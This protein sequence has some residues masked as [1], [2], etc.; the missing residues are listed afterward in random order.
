[1]QDCRENKSNVPKNKVTAIG[2][3]LRDFIGIYMQLT[4]EAFAKNKKG[5]PVHV[6]IVA[7]SWAFA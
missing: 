3:A 5:H 1:M 6:E 7:A 2:P 4:V